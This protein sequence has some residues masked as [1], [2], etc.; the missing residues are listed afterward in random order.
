MRRT[1]RIDLIMGGPG[2]EAAVSRRSGAA[3]A[4][5]LRRLGHD[6]LEIDIAGE[7]DPARLRADAVV[8]NLVHGTYGEDG[9]MQAVLEAAGRAY[10]GSD[11]A[12]S[13]LC[14]DKDA[15]KARLAK[16]GIRVPWGVRIDLSRPFAPRDLKIPHHAGLVLKPACDG[17]SVGL[18]MVANPSFILPAIEEIIREYG[19]QPYLLE[20]RLPGPEY[21]VAVIEDDAGARALPPLLISP[22]QGVFD[23][24]AKYH[25]SDTRE[26]PET[27]A[28]LAQALARLG[29]AAHRACGCRDISRT[30][31]M[32]CADGGLAVLEVNTLPGM[33]DASLAPKAAAAAGMSYDLFSD[34]L[35]QRAAARMNGVS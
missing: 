24:Q 14:M 8:F 3:V 32:R 25:R 30:D 5:A 10:V 33:T 2:R 28:A 29:E 7:L 9:R 1:L 31:I 34:H 19:A 35:V 15:T 22:A 13:R 20:E 12:A 16:A 27:D 11:A 23:Y 26:E 6:V 18:R 21:T 17:S 4:A